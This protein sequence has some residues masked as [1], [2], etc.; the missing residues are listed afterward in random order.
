MPETNDIQGTPGIRYGALRNQMICH[1]PS[2]PRPDKSY[3][4]H[5]ELSGKDFLDCIS[6][7]KS[8]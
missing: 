8:S 1:L 3:P 7:I 6:T 4:L 5:A 2:F